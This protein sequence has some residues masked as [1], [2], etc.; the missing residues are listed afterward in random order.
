MHM[1]EVNEWFQHIPWE[2]VFTAIGVVLGAILLWVVLK[3]AYSH[4]AGKVGTKSKLARVSFSVLRTLL[5]TIVVLT[6]LDICGVNITSAVAGLGIA[7]AVVGLAL[8]DILKDVIMGLHIVSDGFFELGDCVEIDGQEGIVRKFTMKTTKIERILDGSVVSFCNRNIEQARVLSRVQY[9][10]IPLAYTTDADTARRVLTAACDKI[11]QQDGFDSCRFLGTQ[12]F[13][14]SAIL[15]KI[16]ISGPPDQK[17][18]L[19]R[20]ALSTMQ[21]ELAA[22]GI[23]IPFNQLDVHLDK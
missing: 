21:D 10:D 11:A 15:Y 19:R 12:E 22:A 6:I 4:Y 14:S 1:P 17:F 9:L 16:S 3:R 13:A 20:R 2:K 5:A 23:A 7:S 18:S 8:Q